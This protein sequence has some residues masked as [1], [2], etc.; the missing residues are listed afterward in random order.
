MQMEMAYKGKIYRAISLIQ[1]AVI[2]ILKY[3][4]QLII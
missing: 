2:N 1:A 3:L 4:L